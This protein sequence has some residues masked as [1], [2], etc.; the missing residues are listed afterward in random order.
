MGEHTKNEWPS[1]GPFACACRF[2]RDSEFGEARQVDVCGFHRQQC[3][4]LAEALTVL[5][6]EVENERESF[7]QCHST[8]EGNVPE[9]D[10][11]QILAELDAKLNKARAALSR[12][13]CAPVNGGEG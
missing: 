12:H 1:M 4:E 5:V 7:F 6:E 3:A 11:R 8:F 9:Y 13:K 2:V 10:D